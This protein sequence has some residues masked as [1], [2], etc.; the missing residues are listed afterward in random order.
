MLIENLNSKNVQEGE[1]QQSEV[2]GKWSQVYQKWQQ[3]LKI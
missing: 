2:C 3:S 1:K